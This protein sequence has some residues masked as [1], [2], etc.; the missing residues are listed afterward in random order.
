MHNIGQSSFLRYYL[1]VLISVHRQCI[2]L[3]W[4]TFPIILYN[5]RKF[6]SAPIVEHCRP[7]KLF[8]ILLSWL[9]LSI[10]VNFNA[11]HGHH[12]LRAG[13]GY[14]FIIVSLHHEVDVPLHLWHIHLIRVREPIVILFVIP[15]CFI[16]LWFSVVT[17]LER[18]KHN[19][20]VSVWD[21]EYAVVPR[22]LGIN[23]VRDLRN[24]MVTPSWVIR[25]KVSIVIRLR[26]RIS[27]HVQT[28][29]FYTE[30][31]VQR[32]YW[33]NR[34]SMGIWHAIRII[35]LVWYTCCRSSYNHFSNFVN[36]S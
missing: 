28:M 12:V 7:N 1:Y 27:H 20:K 13:P 3:D 5:Y 26:P 19:V 31:I 6:S 30:F 9:N 25:I 32:K 10:P 22:S 2:V 18:V 29:L 21:K 17:H 11:G 34:E 4:C 8:I 23:A 14:D 24:V 15:L 36:Y 33:N 16:A 35:R